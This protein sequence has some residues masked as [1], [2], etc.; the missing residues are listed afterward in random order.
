MFAAERCLQLRE[1]FAAESGVCNAV[2]CVTE[3]EYCFRLLS[4]FVCVQSVLCPVGMTTCLSGCL[5]W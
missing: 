2:F 3:R 4:F 1:M 5:V